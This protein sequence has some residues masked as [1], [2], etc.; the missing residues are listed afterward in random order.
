MSNSCVRKS[1]QIM[2]RP[3]LLAAELG[4]H[5][6]WVLDT[7]NHNVLQLAVMNRQEKKV[8][9]L[10]F[11]MS[12]HKNLLLMSKDNFGNNVLHI[13]GKLAPQN[14]RHHIC[15]AALQM[16][17]ELQWFK[18]VKK[19]VKPAYE[20]DKNSEEKTPAMVCTEEHE[21]LVK[22]G[23]KWTKGSASSCTIA[24]APIATVV[25]AAAITGWKQ[26]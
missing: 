25:F 26:R 10:T 9:K 13:A 8:F 20:E 17:Y 21:K 16:Q 12:H 24:A 6:I 15:G 7:E 4:V 11:Q 1:Q 18:E 23:E 5:V 2:K 3:F 22:E 19:I 14:R